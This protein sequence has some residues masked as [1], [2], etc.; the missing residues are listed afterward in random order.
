[1]NFSKIVFSM[2]VIC[3][4]ISFAPA[5]LSADSAQMTEAKQLFK[6]YKKLGDAF[7]AKLSRAISVQAVS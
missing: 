5:A 4:L 6:S 3:A 2:P 1:M 7:D